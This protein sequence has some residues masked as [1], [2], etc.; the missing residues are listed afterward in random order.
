MLTPDPEFLQDIYMDDL[1][2]ATTYS[3]VGV[4]EDDLNCL[5]ISQICPF[6]Y[7]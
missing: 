6:Q 7:R 1:V 4:F 2:F 5:D 3:S